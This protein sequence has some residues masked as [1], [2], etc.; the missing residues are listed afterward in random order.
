MQHLNIQHRFSNNIFYWC[1]LAAISSLLIY[2][3]GLKGQYDVTQFSSTSNGLKDYGYWIRAAENLTQLKNP[4]DEDPLFKSGIFSSTIIYFFKFL[5]ISDTNFFVFMQILN[6]VGLVIFLLI[7]KYFNSNNTILLF[8]LLT[9]SSTREILVN[10]QVTGI[11]LGLFSA[12]YSL[13]IY[14]NNRKT[15]LKN[16]NYY[17]LS[18]VAGTIFMFLMDIKPN[19]FLF[20]LS[21][22]ALIIP[23][24]LTVL[25]GIFGWLLHQAYYSFTIG[26]VLLISW[27][28]NLLSVVVYKENPNLYGSLGIWQL[29]NQVHFNQY[30]LQILPIITFLFCG[31]LSLRL[32]KTRSISS[33]LFLAFSTNYF[34]TY[35]HFYSFL[36]ILAIMVYWIFLSKHIF[37]AGF[38]VSSMEFSF[39]LNYLNSLLSITLLALVLILYKFP[40]KTDSRFFASGWIT[41][42]VLREGLFFFIPTNPYLIKSIIVMIPF[43]IIAFLVAKESVT[44]THERVGY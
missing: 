42:M 1:V 11:L 10:G 40:K 24:R 21:V 7:F 41:Y 34:Y 17:L 39:N 12:F 4:Y 13:I 32:S 5:L 3:Y 20:P 25:I 26:D 6:I 19:L 2:Q 38:L 37:F 22:L 30:L 33:A 8:V 15:I 27:Y 9:F 43:A 36:P 29:L 16:L 14:T 23:C 44:T 35:F 28:N 18:A 31:Y